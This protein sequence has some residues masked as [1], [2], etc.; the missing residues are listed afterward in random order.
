MKSNNKMPNKYFFVR[1]LILEMK[2]KNGKNRDDDD[3]W[4]GKPKM[5]LTDKYEEN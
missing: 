5:D 2:I 3:I 4:S 1:F